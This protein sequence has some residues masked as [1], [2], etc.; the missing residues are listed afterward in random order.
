MEF[1]NKD[2]PLK[3]ATILASFSEYDE[4]NIANNMLQFNP[5]M[6]VTICKSADIGIAA[7]R[8]IGDMRCRILKTPSSS[9]EKFVKDYIDLG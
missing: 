2:K 1:A 9:V 8:E 4:K 3:I 5:S 7:V 6:L